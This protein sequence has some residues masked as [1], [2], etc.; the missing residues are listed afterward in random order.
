MDEE[1]EVMLEGGFEV[2]VVGR[3]PASSCEGGEDVVFRTR[4]V[5]KKEGKRWR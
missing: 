3:I 2:M 5:S 4:N 1:S